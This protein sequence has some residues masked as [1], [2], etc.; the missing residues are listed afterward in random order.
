MAGLVRSVLNNW[1][2]STRPSVQQRSASARWHAGALTPAPAP[3]PVRAGAGARA[4]VS[5]RKPSARWFAGPASGTAAAAPTVRVEQI[6]DETPTAKTV[7]LA[8][9]DD[10]LRNYRAGQHLTLEVS[11]D[12]TSF[13][14]CYSFST[15]PGAAQPAITVRRVEGGR[16][17]G[18]LFETLRVGQTLKASGP[19]GGFTLVPD[20]QRRAHHVM[21]AGGVGIT[22]LIS[23]V[24]AVLAGEPL[25][26][27]TLL[28]GS[29]SEDDIIFHERLARL[30]EAHPQRL[31]VVLALDRARSRWPGIKGQLGG[32]RVLEALGGAVDEAEF[33]VCGPAAMMDSVIGA[34]TGAGVPPGRIHQERFTYADSARVAHPEGIYAVRFAASGRTLRSTPGEPLLQTATGAGIALPCS[35]QMGGCGQCRIKVASGEVVMDQPNCLSRAEIEAGYILSCCAYPASDLV[36]EGV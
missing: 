8:P 17:S 10:A 30:A 28:Y 9:S 12:G 23:M 31:S 22:P 7:V 6:I 29:R 11:I 27:V 33:Y 35:C 19:S 34:L 25:S 13:R 15:A 5:I 26:R 14:R 1:F 20:A 2:G 24:E 21:I 36:I 32:E 16:V 4:S 18:H 3:L